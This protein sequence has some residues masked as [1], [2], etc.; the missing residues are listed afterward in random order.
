MSI[1]PCLTNWTINH[2]IVGGP[3]IIFTS[4]LCC[5]N[6]N[7]GPEAV[8]LHSWVRCQ[9]PLS[10]S[11]TTAYASGTLCAPPS[12]LWFPGRFISAYYWMDWV[13]HSNCI[14]IQVKNGKGN[15][16]RKVPWWWIHAHH[17][18][19]TERHSLTISWLLL[20]WTSVWF[21]V[22]IQ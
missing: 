5:S 14:D 13:A 19:A 21:H 11:H 2:N 18:L 3:S 17:L 20:E 8:R 1:L 10:T 6:T 4:P 16:S 7:Q 22:G 9:C 15:Q 12:Q